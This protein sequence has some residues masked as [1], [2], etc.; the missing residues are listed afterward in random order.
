MLSAAV[1]AHLQLEG[2]RWQM[3]PLYLVV[4]GL[5]V[6]DVF[7]LERGFQW[8]NRIARG[9]LG[10]IGLVFASV[11]P[12]VLPVPEMPTPGGP[13]EI[14]TFTVQ[15]VDGDR[16]ETYDDSPVGPRE[17]SAQVWYPAEPVDDSPRLPWSEDWE[18]VAPAIAREM[19][20]P[21]WF[22]NHTRFTRS[23]AS[24]SPPVAAGTYPVILYS[25]GW[26]GVRTNSLNQ[27]EHLVSSGYVVIA[28]DHTYASAAT[29][30]EDGEVVYQSPDALPDPEEAEG[31][32][33]REAATR[34]VDT[35]AADLVGILDA[36]D[37]GESGPFDRVVG[38]ADLNRIGIY[39]HA[40][41]GGA[42]IEVCL[43][44]DRC[45]AVLAMDPWVTPLTAEDLQLTM[46][47]PALYM[48][49]E[50]WLGSEDDALVSGIAARGEAITYRVGIEGAATNDF[51]MVPLLSPLADQLGWK[52][53]IPAGRVMTIV[54]NYLLGF[55]NVFLLGTGPAQLDS[56]DFEEVEVSV[57]D[58]RE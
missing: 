25:H 6:G 20:L 36:L 26:S 13:E 58:P 54:D 40:T 56:V 18:V 48:R 42:A 33:Y 12:V 2:F 51:V 24:A 43:E 53:S 10:A 35:F 44:D 31:E 39:G 3:I 34:L 27:I 19:G 21:S 8:S 38:N 4:V 45:E 50:E 1:V 9:L 55:F 28:P 57:F 22:W 11:L 5:A 7:Y 37:Q 17:L 46:T 32:E 47:K 52:G 41:G 49:S 16:E 23:H 14:G 29:V 15:L 30:L